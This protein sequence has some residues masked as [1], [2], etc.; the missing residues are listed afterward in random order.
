MLIHVR[1]VV[2]KVIGKSSVRFIDTLYLRTGPTV[3]IIY[4][5]LD[6]RCMIGWLVNRNQSRY[7]LV[8]IDLHNKLCMPICLLHENFLFI[9]FTFSAY[10]KR[11][12]SSF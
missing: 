9:M 4:S 6:I 12:E 10:H 3:F 2:A 1:I 11:I 5:V 8:P 7:W